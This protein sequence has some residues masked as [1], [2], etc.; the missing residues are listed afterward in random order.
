MSGRGTDVRAW[1][2]EQAESRRGHPQN[3]I[4]RW[5]NLGR[6]QEQP[7]LLTSGPS[8]QPG[9][10][11][12]SWKIKVPWPPSPTSQLHFNFGKKR[13]ISVSTLIASY[14]LNT[15]PPLSILG[16]LFLFSGWNW[17]RGLDIPVL[18]KTVSFRWVTG[19]GTFAMTNTSYPFTSTYLCADSSKSICRVSSKREAMCLCAW[20]VM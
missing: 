19:T 7:F 13:L 4:H 5:Q 8:L 18:I 12:I 1:V 20:R 10:R 6:P 3:W 11:L 9:R 16:D 17:F 2:Q 15:F 14:P